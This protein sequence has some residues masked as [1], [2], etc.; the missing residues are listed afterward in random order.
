MISGQNTCL[1]DIMGKISDPEK[2]KSDPDYKDFQQ[3]IRRIIELGAQH[4]IAAGDLLILIGKVFGY[5]WDDIPAH[6]FNE[7]ESWLNINWY[8]TIEI[9]SPLLHKHLME[10]PNEYST[11]YNSMQSSEGIYHGD[12]DSTE[13]ANQKIQT[14]V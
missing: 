14:N 12:S 9:I 1:R 4:D 7:I 3:K 5:R 11:W 10:T 2:L 8:R 13:S 6:K